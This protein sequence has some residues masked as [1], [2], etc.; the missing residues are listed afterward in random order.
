MVK[1]FF[2]FELWGF[3]D[4]VS[5]F[6]TGIFTKH[7]MNNANSEFNRSIKLR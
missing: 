3:K 5:G 6:C 4:V 7:L 1:N 2:S